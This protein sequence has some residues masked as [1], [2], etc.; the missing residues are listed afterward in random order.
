VFK[1]L[2]NV[3]HGVRHEADDKHPVEQ[4]DGDAMRGH[5]LRPLDRADAAVRGEDDDGGERRLEGAVQVGEAL[6]VE[7]VHLV[8]EEDARD[9]LGDAL[10]DVPVHDLVDLRPQLVRDLRFLRLLSWGGGG[11]HVRVCVCARARVCQC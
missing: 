10:V 5:N 9:E 3:L 11:G 4:I 2:D 6:D 1:Y 8:D 7:H